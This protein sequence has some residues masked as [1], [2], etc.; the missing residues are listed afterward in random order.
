[1]LI[2][3]IHFQEST[4]GYLGIFQSSQSEFEVEDEI[5]LLRVLATQAAP[6]LSSAV[7]D[8][9]ALSEA[10]DFNLNMKRRIQSSISAAE[11]DGSE[12]SFALLRFMSLGESQSPDQL[13]TMRE[14]WFRLVRKGL[15]DGRQL[16]WAGLDSLLVVAPGGNPVG[17]E[18]SCADLRRQMEDLQPND[19]VLQPVSMA[20]AIQ[21]YPFDQAE[22]SG[23]ADN[24]SMGLINEVGRVVSHA[25]G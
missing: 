3:P 4:Q 16:W 14:S 25:E 9:L 7:V 1:M 23:M 13:L 15:G 6:I 11:R 22:G 10:D 5:V 21:T 19:D 12:V 20:Y 18:H 2:L 17:L 8:S 24:L